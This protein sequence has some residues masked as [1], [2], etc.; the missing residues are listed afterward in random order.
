MQLTSKDGNMIVDFYPQG[1]T[2]KRYTKCVTF[3]NDLKSWS[4]V[5]ATDLKNEVSERIALGYN[6]TDFNTFPAAEYSPV[7]C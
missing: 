4:T 1:S 3:A 5:L 7:S 6:V 2:N